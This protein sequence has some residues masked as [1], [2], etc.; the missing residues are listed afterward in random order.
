MAPSEG[1]PRRDRAYTYL[2]RLKDAVVSELNARLAR[3]G[4]L[5]H[6]LTREMAF[7]ISEDSQTPGTTRLA[8]IYELTK[9]IFSHILQ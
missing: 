5:V 8:A 2:S 7:T 9:G 3:K 1:S 6:E 4:E